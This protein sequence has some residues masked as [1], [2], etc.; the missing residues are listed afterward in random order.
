[1]EG[2]Y[3]PY[4][5]F[6]M[7]F[8]NKHLRSMSVKPCIAGKAKKSEMLVKFH[9]SELR[10]YFFPPSLKS[11]GSFVTN[12]SGKQETSI[13]SNNKVCKFLELPILVT[14]CINICEMEF[15]FMNTVHRTEKSGVKKSFLFTRLL[16]KNNEIAEIHKLQPYSVSK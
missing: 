14:Q 3:T 15:Y 12:K 6:F 11:P 1:V 16:N 13:S 8:M 10:R 9:G 5:S 4:E 2:A 7:K